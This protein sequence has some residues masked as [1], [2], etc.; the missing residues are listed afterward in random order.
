MKLVTFIYKNKQRIGH[1]YGD[2][3][4][5]D[6][7]NKGYVVD[8]ST[9]FDYTDMLDFIKR[10]GIN[11]NEVKKYIHSDKAK[12]YPVSEVTLTTPINPRSLRDA[13]AFRQHVETS[14][15]NRGLKMIKEFDDFPVYYYS[16]VDGI[17]I[18][19][20]PLRIVLAM[21]PVRSP[22]VPPPIAIIVEDLLI[23]FFNKIEIIFQ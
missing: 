18:N 15:K 8:I 19:F 17:K 21:K 9:S 3:N 6:Y 20:T 7:N 5:S 10:D 1:L 2:I 12:K 14:R 4:N 22:I 11:S 16:N 23:L 13:Y